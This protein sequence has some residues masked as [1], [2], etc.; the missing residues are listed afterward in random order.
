MIDEIK[1][2]VCVMPVKEMIKKIFSIPNI[3]KSVLCTMKNLQNCE[4]LKSV[5]NGKRWDAILKNYPRNSII[6]PFDL[7]TD[8]FETGNALG[9]NSGTHKIAGYYISFPVFPSHIVASTK[10]IFEVLLYETKLKRED[11]K[12]CLENLVQI[13]Q[14]LEEEGV[15]LTID[16]KETKVFFVMTRIFGD[17][18]GLNEI[19]GFTKGF[20]ANKFCRF[21]NLSKN[22]TRANIH[23]KPEDLRTPDKHEKDRQ[24]DDFSSTGIADIC[25]FDTLK[26][27]H[28][29]ENYVCDIMHDL[30][31]GIVKYDIPMI[32]E[33][34]FNDDTI[35]LDLDTL[36]HLKQ[37]FCYGHIE[38]GNLSCEITANNIKNSS[39]KMSASEAK[40]FL[41]FLPL[42][43]GQYIEANN[44]YYEM[45]LNLLDISDLI[46]LSSFN[47]QS[48][49]K[50]KTRIES[51]LHKYVNLFGRNLKPKHHYLTHYVLC[52]EYCGP[53]R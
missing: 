36:N 5:I 29:T 26:N 21:C 33:R 7:Y 3:L 53:L 11:M 1:E 45:L 14:D 32:L 13:F 25:L 37:N 28:C 35:D 50:L 48:L 6:I 4:S 46:M 47:S 9:S 18:L 31:E 41:H 20:N 51:Y 43:I 12:S 23:P 52:I 38:I 44:K 8:D 10:Y 2:T 15:E 39:L 17:N 19:L 16:G 22:Q 24:K 40:T 42:M 49:V 27:F 30:Y 34:F